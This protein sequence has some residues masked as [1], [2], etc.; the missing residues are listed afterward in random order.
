MKSL[1]LPNRYGM[2]PTTGR[3]WPLHKVM[4]QHPRRPSVAA[5]KS[6]K[7]AFGPRFLGVLLGIGSRMFSAWNSARWLRDLHA[8]QICP[9]YRPSIRANRAK[10]INRRYE[11]FTN[12]PGILLTLLTM[13]R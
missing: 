13:L 11:F 4:G 3:G 10:T 7:S 2:A 12:L 6:M 8:R 1:A 5:A 9:G